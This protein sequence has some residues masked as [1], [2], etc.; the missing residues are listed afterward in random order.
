MALLPI[1]LGGAAA[2]GA[3]NSLFGKGGLFGG[4][5]RNRRERE[6]RRKSSGVSDFFRGR[7]DRISGE[8]PTQSQTF[9]QGLAGLLDLIRDRRRGD[10]GRATALG[11][12]GGELELAQAAGR[13]RTLGGG[14]RDLLSLSERSQQAREGQAGSQLLGASSQ[15]LT[16]LLDLIR[17]KRQEQGQILGL[18]GSLG[19]S[20]GTAFG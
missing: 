16:A 19:Q 13:Q 20:A 3:A 6:L 15:R 1:L 7:L 18:F 9:K 5:R 2:A 12:Q 10:E 8:S 14:F 4:G 11:A 17:G